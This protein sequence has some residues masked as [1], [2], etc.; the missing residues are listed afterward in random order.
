MMG[1]PEKDLSENYSGAFDGHLRPG[2]QHCRHSLGHIGEHLQTAHALELLK[3]TTPLRTRLDV[4][5]NLLKE[6]ST[7]ARIADHPG[8]A[9]LQKLGIRK[10][11]T[12]S[13]MRRRGQ[14]TAQPA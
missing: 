11:R 5:A 7:A 13:L 2:R 1:R 3:K 8:H 14:R 6:P 9:E 10:R 12:I 4:H